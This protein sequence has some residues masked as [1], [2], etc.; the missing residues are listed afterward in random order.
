MSS[1]IPP[2]SHNR[3]GSYT[4]EKN[5]A[6][7]IQS[8]VKLRHTARLSDHQIWSLIRLTWITMGTKGVSSNHW[9]RLK[10]PALESLFGNAASANSD[11]SATIDSMGLPATVATAAK[12]ETGMINFRGT[13]RN[14]SRKWCAQNLDDLRSIISDA[15]K[16]QSD[17][18]ARFDLASRIDR[19]PPVKSP[20]GT[21][22]ASAGVLLTPLIACLD[23]KSRFPI[24]N[25]RESVRSVLRKLG[26]AHSALRDK[27]QGM[28]RILGRNDDAFMLDVMG[29]KVV[30]SGQKPL[31]DYDE[32]E[33]EA[34][35]ES[36]TVTYEKRHN[37]MTN[38]LNRIFKQFNPSIEPST[39]AGRY[40]ALLNRY[41]ATGQDLLIEAKPDGDRGSIRIAIGQLFDYR[42]YIKRHAAT[43][44]ALLTIA[45]PAPDYIELLNDL[46]I[47]AMWF[48]NENCKQ[49]AGGKGKAWPPIAAC[50]G[51][52]AAN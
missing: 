49:I 29:D 38:A 12:E 18:H 1:L 42:R 46:G 5:T 48:G 19:L 27:V 14:A 40:D 22:D 52:K 47:T 9:T 50:I 28:I 41:D 7:L 21:A 51:Q 44:L 15:A 17:D 31:R 39:P 32:D 34:V 36:R 8:I 24:V 11:L 13:W 10:V 4:T 26:L 16:L 2:V 25:G 20:N 37:R 33:R 30:I 43:D 6:A 23:Q 35:F 45:R 3:Q